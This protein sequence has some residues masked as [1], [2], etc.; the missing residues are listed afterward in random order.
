[1]KQVKILT[2]IN[3][4]FCTINSC[5]CQI[6]DSWLIG[7]KDSNLILETKFCNIVYSIDN[8]EE[9]SIL[10]FN[11]TINNRSVAKFTILGNGFLEIESLKKEYIMLLQ[12]VG[13]REKIAVCLPIK[14]D[15][16]E[17]IYE[18]LIDYDSINNIVITSNYDI[19]RI[20]LKIINI[21]TNK[22]LDIY[23]LNVCT[24]TCCIHCIKEIEYKHGEL[25][26]KWYG[27]NNQ[28]MKEL[29]NINSIL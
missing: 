4:I 6:N 9:Y 14:K 11:D 5:F 17:I 24:A 10:W 19:D 28:E 15:A 12:E 22:Y 25:L 20:D 29:Y 2:F 23:I 3:L 8:N 16:K 18:N 1:M 7:M 27:K 21:L 26:I 13:Q